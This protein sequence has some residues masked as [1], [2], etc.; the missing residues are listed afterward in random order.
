MLREPHRMLTAL[1]LMAAACGAPAVRAPEPPPRPAL[2]AAA[3]GGLIARL[4]EPGGYFPSENLVSNE[5]SYLHVMGALQRLGTRGGA[6]IGVGPDQNFSWIAQIRPEIAFII[7]I[8]R[9]N[10]LEQFLFKALFAMARNRLEYLCLMTGTPVPAGPERWDD[11]DIGTIVAYVDSTKSDPALM[12]RTLDDVRARV[13][14][15]GY[16]LDVT[17]LEGIRRIHLAFFEGGLDVRYSNR[18]RYVFYPTWRQLILATDLEG[19]RA[20]YLATEERW[21]FVK[22]LE[23]RNRIV[24]VVGDLA[25]AHALSGISDVVR[26]RG[27]VVSAF[28]TS[29]V[30]QYLFQNGTF[31]RFGTSVTTLPSGPNS[32]II[33]SYFRGRHPQNVPGHTSTQ[34]LVRLADFDRSFAAGEYRTYYDVVTL[35]ALPL[36]PRKPDGPPQWEVPV[37][38]PR[39]AAS[40]RTP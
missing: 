26:R 39:T 29:N 4:S 16:P 38:W 20:G 30:E 21:R 7:D 5:T 37:P 14:A 1:S 19:T 17:D 31:P 35:N 33:R 8:R 15:W 13:Q 22:D 10:L 27:L 36:L 25:G 3:F 2:D 23:R 24:P 32:V 6:Y 12:E 40:R 18:G 11:A 34:V 28:Y 9:D